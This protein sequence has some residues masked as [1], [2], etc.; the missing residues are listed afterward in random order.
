MLTVLKALA[1]SALAW[2][3][4]VSAFLAFGISHGSASP[5]PEKEGTGDRGTLVALGDSYISGDGR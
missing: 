4:M 5:L 1:I 2:L 3:I